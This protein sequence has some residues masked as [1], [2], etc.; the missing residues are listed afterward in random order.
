MMKPYKSFV[1]HV[2]TKMYKDRFKNRQFLS[3]MFI[4]NNFVSKL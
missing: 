4:E 3:H 2:L 1:R